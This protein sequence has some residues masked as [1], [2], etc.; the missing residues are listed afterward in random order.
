MFGHA[1]DHDAC[2]AADPKP[3]RNNIELNEIRCWEEIL[4]RSDQTSKRFF[5]ANFVFTTNECSFIRS[6]VFMH[7]LPRTKEHHSCLERL[8]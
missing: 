4:I 8:P 5:F 6:L 7:I 1:N 2:K 3:Y